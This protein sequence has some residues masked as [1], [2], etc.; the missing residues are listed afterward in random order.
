MAAPTS[1]QTVQDV[2]NIQNKA[3]TIISGGTS[4]SATKQG[5]ELIQRIKTKEIEKLNQ[6]KDTLIQL[7]NQFYK[8]AGIRD[9][10]QLYFKTV[11]WKNSGAASILQNPQIIAEIQNIFSE[12]SMANLEQVVTEFNNKTLTK[13]QLIAIFGEEINQMVP[14]T[15]QL[16]AAGIKGGNASRKGTLSISLSTSQVKGV[17]KSFTKSQN[18]KGIT[19]FQRGSSSKNKKENFEIHFTQD[20]PSS[21]QKKLTD[22]FLEIL[23][24]Q[25]TNIQLEAS[26]QIYGKI[27]QK[28]LSYLPSGHYPKANQAIERVIQRILVEARQVAISKNSSVIRGALG[29]IYWNAFFDFLEIPTIPVGFDVHDAS[30]KELPTDIVFEKFGFQVKNYKTLNGIVTF[31][32]HFDRNLEEMVPNQIPLSRFFSRTLELGDEGAAN[33]GKFY[34][35]QQYNIRD[36]EK[37][38]NNKYTEVEKRFSP[39]SNAI[40]TFIAANVHKM[41]NMDKNITLK[42]PELFNPAFNAG[43]PIIFFINENPFPASEIIQEI[44]N[45]LSS[46]FGSSVFINIQNLNLNTSSFDTEKKWDQDIQP[47]ITGRLKSAYITYTIDVQVNNLLERILSK[48]K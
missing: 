3:L 28:I 47:D 39:I 34:F 36:V 8:S 10:R 37:D 14:E 20:I 27:K 12:A 6:L 33:L 29:E 31:N 4:T 16:V 45:G 48:I 40:N 11:Q 32:Q 2:I 41:L 13:E 38:T 5:Q 7:E 25:D 30:G 15:A 23:K 21:E 42:Q 44:I 43:R 26:A 22:K 35:S 18:I 1:F 17:T 9:Y 19:F 46:E 24:Q